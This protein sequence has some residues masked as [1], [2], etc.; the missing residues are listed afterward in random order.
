MMVMMV[1]NSACSTSFVMSESEHASAVFLAGGDDAMMFRRLI[2]PDE[3]NMVWMFFG[4]YRWV[5]NVVA[6]VTFNTYKQNKKNNI[7]AF[8]FV[9]QALPE[10]FFGVLECV[11][12][13]SVGLYSET[14]QSGVCG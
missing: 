2:A 9:L 12:C 5:R 6:C 3:Q 11:F 10:R 1:R 13:I 8:F 14:C 7:H 4:E